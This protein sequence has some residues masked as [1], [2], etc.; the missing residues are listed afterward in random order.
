MS[1]VLL[2]DG[3]VVLYQF[4]TAVEI[5]IRW[6]DYIWTLHSDAREAMQKV[7][8]WVN[9]VM[10]KLQ[11]SKV[12]MAFS[13]SDN[14]RKEVLPTY[15]E[16]RKGGRKPLCFK[17]LREYIE[18]VYPSMCLPTLEADDVLGM[19]ATGYKESSLPK[20]KIIVSI[21]KDLKTIPGL[22][23]NP[24]HPSKGTLTISQEEADYNHLKQ[25]LM[26][27]SVDGYSGCP[28]IGPK[29]AEKLLSTP[30]WNTVVQAYAKAGLTEDDALV[31]ARVARILRHGEYNLTH[32]KVRLWE[33]PK[34]KING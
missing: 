23:Y 33:P 12:I 5:P 9:K 32:N 25:A 7:D 10:D 17:E 4:S 19:L 11:A 24:D 28:G 14:W 6:D 8:G 22:L 21:D 27:D 2:I 30:S 29:T 16:H 15:K 26:G 1:R 18:N 13:D 3:D 20:E 31:Q 34:E